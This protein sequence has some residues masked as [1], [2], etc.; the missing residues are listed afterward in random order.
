MWSSLDTFC[1]KAHLWCIF[2]FHWIRCST[3][4]EGSH[5]HCP[6]VPCSQTRVCHEYPFSTF[7]CIPVDTQPRVNQRDARVSDAARPQ[8]TRFPLSFQS[9]HRQTIPK[10]DLISNKSVPQIQSCKR[11]LQD[12]TQVC[13]KSPVFRLSELALSLH[14]VHGDTQL[15]HI[16]LVGIR[17]CM[18]NLGRLFELRCLSSYL[19][20]MDDGLSSLFLYSV[21][22]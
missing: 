13:A 14:H 4:P 16:W 12:S 5:V 2:E 21:S 20:V 17:K 7:V 15:P 18:R 8:S 9:R 19:I 3:C 1:Y 22:S 11:P 6:C 10:M